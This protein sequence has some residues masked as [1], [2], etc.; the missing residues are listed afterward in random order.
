LFNFTH[1]NLPDTFVLELVWKSVDETKIIHV[2]SAEPFDKAIFRDYDI[3]VTG[4]A[5]AQ[6]ENK[7]LVKDLLIN[8]WV[9]ARVSPGQKVSRLKA[10]DC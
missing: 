2:N 1:Q 7:P 3:C 5:L 10:Y 9:Y 6:Y 4:A 8:T